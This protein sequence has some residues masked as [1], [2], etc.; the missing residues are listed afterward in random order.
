MK[1]HH[2]YSDKDGVSHFK[3]IEIDFVNRSSTG[4]SET[5]A[6]VP[7]KSLIFRKTAPT[8]DTDWHPA[9]RRQYFVNLEGASQITASD[10]EVR[11]IEAGEIVLLEDVSGKG[12]LSKAI[13][14]I[15]KHSL[16]ITLD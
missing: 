2:L 4:G 7:V 9:P 10:G 11:R 1:I 12:H 15:F 5:S 3:D 13:D 6:P 8:L 14:K 16:F